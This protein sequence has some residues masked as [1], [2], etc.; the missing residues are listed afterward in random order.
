MHFG[1]VLAAALIAG[2]VC[3]VTGYLP[4][5]AVCVLV[6]G[7]LASLLIAPKRKCRSCGGSRSH[8]DVMGSGGHRRC[9]TCGG[10]GEYSRW[11]TAVLRPG[12]HKQI[13]AGKHGRNW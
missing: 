9:W 2:T 5:V 3:L 6:L 10:R 13:L 4:G 11:G 12:V 7:Y 1:T 8:G